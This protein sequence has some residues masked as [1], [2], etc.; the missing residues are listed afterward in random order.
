MAVNDPGVIQQVVAPAVLVPACGLLLLS[1][2]ARMNTVLARVRAFH[3]E[4]LDIWRTEHVV[5]SRHDRVRTLRLDGLQRQTAR[6][7]QRAGLIRLTMLSLFGAIICNLLS[8]IALGVRH[9]TGD[10]QPWWY[11]VSVGLF[12]LGVLL[13]LVSTV[14]SL[15]EVSRSVETVRYETERVDALCRSDAPPMPPMAPPPAGVHDGRHDG[16]GTGL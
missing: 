14:T 10:E 7:L 11:S 6:L 12:M 4:Q 5:G 9:V 2:S 16:E 3:A 8:I 15:M 13:M 1:S